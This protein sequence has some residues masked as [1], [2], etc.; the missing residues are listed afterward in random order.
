LGTFHLA[1]ASLVGQ[2]SAMIA[3]KDLGMELMPVIGKRRR[4]GVANRRALEWWYTLAHYLK[5]GN[6]QT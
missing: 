3:W 6:Q 1:V 4:D 5:G 2:L